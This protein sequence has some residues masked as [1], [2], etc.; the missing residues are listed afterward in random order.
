MCQ[1]GEGGTGFARLVRSLVLTVFQ[2]LRIAKRVLAQGD[3][4]CEMMLQL[5]ALGARAYTHAHT[6]TYTYTLKGLRP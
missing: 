5:K 3:V 4:V 1:W 6:H 2:R